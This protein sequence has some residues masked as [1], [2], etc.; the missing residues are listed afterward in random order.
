MFGG[1][2]PSIY[3][4]IGGVDR[5]IWMVLG[6]LLALAAVCPF[7][8]SISDIIGRRWVAIGGS[9]FIILGMIVVSTAHTMN[10]V[11]CKW[12]LPHPHAP[13]SG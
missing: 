2:I 10:I 4:D 5:W 6:N 7:V 1:I 12:I 8:G 11:I 3:S 9:C 13:Q